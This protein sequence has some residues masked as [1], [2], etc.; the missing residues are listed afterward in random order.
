MLVGF[1]KRFES[2]QAVD[3]SAQAVDDRDVV[4]SEE[5]EKLR[6][7]RS[8]DSL[9]TFADCPADPSVME[10]PRM[11]Q[12]KALRVPVQQ[13]CVAKRSRGY[14]E[15]SPS[16]LPVIKVRADSPIPKSVVTVFQPWLGRV[17]P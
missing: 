8:D 3:F 17:D 2:A 15:A 1:L 9:Q 13:E 16:Q 5:A 6:S 7:E 14:K 10:A 12:R 11:L 4:L